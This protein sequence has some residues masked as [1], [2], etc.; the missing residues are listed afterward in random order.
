MRADGVSAATQRARRL[1]HRPGAWIEAADGGYAVRTGPDRRSRIAMT[2]DEAAFR[3][4]AEDPGLKVRPNGGWILRR[5]VA[6]APSPPPGRPG[7]TGG[8]RLVMDGAGRME[9]RPANLTHSAVAWL[10]ARRDSEGRPWIDRAERAA[11]ERLAM[12]AEIALA[13]PSLT[14]RWDALPR[15]GGGSAA[16]V[17]PDDRAHA[18]ARRMEAALAA[19]GP[20]RAMVEQVCI[21]ATPLQAAEQEL[22]LRRREGKA[23]LKAGLRALTAHYR[24]G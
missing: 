1:L 23:L 21:R 10:A 8:T 15:S 24:I 19:C 9:T 18:A 14:L 4:L 17:E 13:G 3:R 2:L 7:L 20:A 6:A 5:S 16:R 22:G 12:D 11:A